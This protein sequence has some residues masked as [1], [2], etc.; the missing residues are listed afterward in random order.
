M[1]NISFFCYEIGSTAHIAHIVPCCIQAPSDAEF[2]SRIIPVEGNRRSSRYRLQ[3]WVR[4]TFFWQRKVSHDLKTGEN[5][6]AIVA[7]HLSNTALEA[8]SE[9]EIG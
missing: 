1:L 8:V 4:F 6:P 5:L 3:K 2:L 7:L 9:A